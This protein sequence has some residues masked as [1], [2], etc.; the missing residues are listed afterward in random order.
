MGTRASGYLFVNRYPDSEMSTWVLYI[1]QAEL[2]WLWT[3]ASLPCI[4]RCSEGLHIWC[5]CV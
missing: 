1:Y 4:I 3:I 2:Q 5:S